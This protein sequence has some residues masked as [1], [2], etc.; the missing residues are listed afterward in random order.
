LGEVDNVQTKENVLT[1]KEQYIDEKGI[2]NV[3]IDA[4]IIIPDVKSFPVA[5]MVSTGFSDEHLSKM[6]ETF[7]TGNEIYDGRIPATKEELEQ[8]ILSLQA[9]NQNTGLKNNDKYLEYLKGLYNEAPD[10]VEY[11]PIKPIWQKDESGESNVNLI[12]LRE[13][14]SRAKING[15]SNDQIC[16]MQYKTTAGEY[17]ISGKFDNKPNGVQKTPDAAETEAKQIAKKMGLDNAII[18]SKNIGS[19]MVNGPREILNENQCYIFNLSKTINGIPFT[20]VD[21]ASGE[22]MSDDKP[23]APPVIQES[24]EVHINDSGAVY[25]SWENPYE[26]TENISENVELIEFDEIKKIFRDQMKMDGIG[27][28]EWYGMNG[29]VNDCINVERI[30]LGMMVT[31][32]K[33]N[34]DEYLCIPVWDFFASTEQ[35]YSD[36]KETGNELNYSILTVNAINGSIINRN[37]GY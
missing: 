20:H 25:F 36:R 16:L 22:F 13:D 21:S 9:E 34:P 29:I 6:V 11:V 17:L 35:T 24:I 1:W 4:Q 18:V 7:F 10:K 3:N 31:I 14:G 37:L 5:R 23:Y 33:D 19:L 30:E 12:E 2:F 27:R 8:T 28:N 15:T 32:E 26:A